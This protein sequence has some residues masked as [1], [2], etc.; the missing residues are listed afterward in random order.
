MSDSKLVALTAVF[1]ALAC[2]GGDD[3]VPGD[4]SPGGEL[5]TIYTGEVGERLRASDQELFFV[6][7]IG[8]PTRVRAVAKDG[9]EARE[10]F[11]ATEPGDYVTAF[12][13]LGDSVFVCVSNSIDD[14]VRVVEAPAGGGESRTVGALVEASGCGGVVASGGVLFIWAEI[15]GVDTLVAMTITDGAVAELE[16]DIRE[17]VVSGETLYALK[18][19]SNDGFTMYHLSRRALGGPDAVDFGPDLFFA[20]GFPALAVA[21]DTAAVISASH[22]IYAVSISTGEVQRVTGQDASV[23]V[24]TDGSVLYWSRTP[25]LDGERPGS[26]WTLP[27]GGG[28]ESPLLET[29]VS[30]SAIVLDSSHIYARAVFDPTSTGIVKIP[31]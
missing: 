2:G 31:R 30:L 6:D 7:G 21:G 18:G 19:Y 15:D 23:S 27:L 3:D 17:I 22:T 8:F 14:G 28:T 11:E 9:G 26:L 10:V 13:V 25:S 20:L 16:S 24:A 29:D 4:G 1:A 12:E 5:A